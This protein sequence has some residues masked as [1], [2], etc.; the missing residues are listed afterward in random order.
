MRILFGTLIILVASLATWVGAV[1]EVPET[2]DRSPPPNA[3]GLA[4]G[5]YAQILTS[6]G[7]IL[8]LLFPQQA[9]QSVAHFA[10]LAE[11]RL[12]W[13][14]PLTG[15]PRADP[16]Y[17]GLEV[18]KVV[19]SQR[20]E[21]GDPTGTGRGAAP[22]YV[23]PE[24]SGPKNFG[25]G[26]RLGMTRGSLN[27]ISGSLFFVTYDPAPWLNR[28]HPCF[29]EVVS[30]KETVRRITTTK[31]NSSGKPL[32]TVRLED[33]R[34]F[35]I[36]DPGPLPEPVPFTPEADQIRIRDDLGGN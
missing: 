10:A 18:H 28:R 1:D 2:P 12:E 7:E 19:A 20:F 15:L 14:D 21:V 33:I 4:P 8:A 5:W 25:Q 35:R 29:G 36:G 13:I 17:R 16:Y 9:P 34:I 26:H 31:A 3:A 23:P 32:E 27:R 24:G 22:F 30:G 11:G 6:E